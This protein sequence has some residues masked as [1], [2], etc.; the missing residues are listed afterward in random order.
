M[1]TEVFSYLASADSVGKGINKKFSMN[2]NK[3]R[4]RS[5]S[6]YSS[7]SIFYY[8]VITSDQVSFSEMGMISRML[9]R[10]Y[11]SFTVA[12]ISLMPFHRVRAD[13]KASIE[14]YLSQFHQNIGIKGADGD[15]MGKLIQALGSLEESATADAEGLKALQ[16]FLM[17]C[18]EKSKA[19]DSDFIKIVNETI[20]I[21]DMYQI[22]PIDPKTKV[23]QEQYMRIQDELA[24]WGFI[25]EATDTLFD[26]EDE[27]ELLNMSDEEIFSKVLSVEM[28]STYDDDDDDIEDELPDDVLDEGT[29][30]GAIDNIK[31]SLESVSENKIMSCSNLTKLA[32]LEA[33]LN[34]LKNK[35]A[36]YLNRYKKKYKENQKSGSKSK[37]AIRFNNVTISNPKLFMQKYGAYIKV[38]NKRLK[39]VEKRRA[40]LRKRKGIPADD[41]KLQENVITDLTS[42]DLQA[43]DHCIEL[44]ESAL[45]APDSEIFILTESKSSQVK[46]LRNRVDYLEGEIGDRNADLYDYYQENEDLKKQVKDLSTAKTNLIKESKKNYAQYET[47]ARKLE[48]ERKYRGKMTDKEVERRVAMEMKEWEKKHRNDAK[49]NLP[50]PP[51]Q[52]PNN[53]RDLIKISEGKKLDLVYDK[54]RNQ[55]NVNVAM[56]AANGQ[57]S[58]KTFDKEVF[59][60]MDMKKV[61]DAVPTFTH[62]SIGF[63]VDETEEVVTRDVLVG[64][65][66]YV[67]RV[68]SLELINDIY[69][70]IINQRKFLK[71]VKFISGEEKSLT[72]LLFGFKELRYDALDS[73]GGAG[74]WRS[75]FKRRKRLTK[76]SIPYLMKEYTPNGTIIMT[77]NEVDF[78]KSEYGVDVM[79]P[80]HVNMIMENDFL[81][82]FVVVDQTNEVVYV[83][84]D[85]HGGDFQEYTYAMLE[86]SEQTT[87]RMMRELYR[88]MAR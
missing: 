80:A 17:E 65:K 73:K 40:E 2:M 34:K 72:D 63:I 57:R 36:K 66:A 3:N 50:S 15:K 10:S 14:D 56:A 30:K 23:L 20:S 11:A 62:A 82:G 24:T 16:D 58:F 60:N 75:A 4:I 51:P 32:S 77:K 79:D 55:S 41:K 52:G 13:D 88:T 31:F 37:L 76:M 53:P 83:T 78:I 44:M 47:E 84:Y 33:K 59:T 6:A 67:H 54:S 35:Y 87:D 74:K 25:G 18:W 27:E 19:N 70:C 8:P 26:D 86:R 12:C 7:N 68:A 21:N 22:D 61:N 81:L 29:V 43:I 48:L 9:E 46:D 71:F 64:I 42:M 28:G 69:N 5:I 38:I 85:G 49:S 1:I 39:L 45:N